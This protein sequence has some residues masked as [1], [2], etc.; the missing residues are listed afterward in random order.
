MYSV[1]DAYRTAIASASYDVDAYIS[2]STAVDT[3]AADDVESISGDFLPMSNSAQVI[4]AVYSL[5]PGLATF[6]GQGIPTAT[7]AGMITPPQEATD[8]PPETGIWS[9]GISDADGAVE[10]SATILLSAEHTSAIRL[11][12]QDVAVTAASFEFAN[13]SGTETVEAE[14][15]TDWIQV[16]KARTFSQVKVSIT[17]L[18]SPYMHVRVVEVE[19]GAGH[20]ISASDLTGSLS[21]ISELDPTENALPLT[22]LDFSV[23]NVEGEF[24]PDNP[25]TRLGEMAIGY[26]LELSFTVVSSDGDKWTV[27]M[28]RF[29]IAE[30]SS[31]ETSLSVSAFDPRHILSQLYVAWS[32]DTAETWGDIFEAVL[33]EHGVPHLVDTGLFSVYPA[34]AHEF[35]TET[36]LL[37]DFLTIQQAYA[38]YLVPDHDGTV[39]A[40]QTWPGG[41]YGTVPVAR[42]I[43]WPGSQQTDGYNYIEVGYQTSDDNGNDATTVISEDLRTDPNA[44]K[45][46]LQITGNPLI[47]TEAR[48]RTLLSRIKSRLYT[49]EVE[50][51][52]LGDPAM[53]T[54]DSAS[55]PGRWTQDAPMAYTVRYVELDYTGGLLTATVKAVQ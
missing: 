21:V 34:D 44:A 18:A 35:T 39:H 22:E 2:I 43:S 3:T 52:A 46:A 32:I 26:P 15:G 24:D 17:G 31:S 42:L 25:D 12:T 47:R 20:T 50:T 19:F 30:R 49:S 51:T 38:I 7:S 23:I 33:T 9:S 8:Y 14:C 4:D 41:S 13:S 6:E 37:D 36:A 11:Y 10:F 27:P 48:A 29:I 40:T 45:V 1:T 54:G 16:S 55:I 53:D 28:G 5:T